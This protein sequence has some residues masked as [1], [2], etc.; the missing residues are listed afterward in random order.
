[1]FDGESSGDLLRVMRQASRRRRRERDA[2]MER[3]I[4]A[5][6]AD[7]VRECALVHLPPAAATRLRLVHPTWACRISSPLFAVVHAAAPRLLS[8]VFVPSAGFLPFD[9]TDT[10]PSPSLS[11]VPTSSD[12]VVLSSSHGIACCFSPHDDAYAVC[13]PATALWTAVPSPPRRSWPRP[14]IVVLFDTSIY[15]FRGDYTLVCPFDSAP[16]SGA[17]FF[18]VFTSGTGTWLITDAMAL[19]EG[20]VPASGVAAGGTAWWRTSIGT[21]V[22]YNPV[23]GRVDLVL[24]PGDSGQWEIGSAADKLHCAVRDGCDVVVFR[25]HEHGSWVEAARVAVSEILQSPWTSTE[26]V[27]IRNP[28]PADE[29]AQDAASDETDSLSSDGTRAVFAAFSAG[30]GVRLLSFQSAE[31]E[32]VVLAGRRLVAFDTRARRRREVVLPD[33]VGTEWDGAEHAAHTNTLALVAPVILAAQP[34]LA[35]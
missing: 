3:V 20:L 25:L 13:N 11:F 22:G 32:V 35:E 16:G 8:G 6:L 4:C 14:A 1:M 33:Q 26:I 19:A 9:G 18:Q 10:V 21:A 15:N 7:V 30:D 17:Y 23:T 5:P 29:H 27:E 12:L 24:C 31:V 34:A 28:E 2:A